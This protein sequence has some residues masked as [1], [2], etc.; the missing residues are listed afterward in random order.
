MVFTAGFRIGRFTV[1]KKLGFGGMGEVYLAEDRELNRQVALKFLPLPLC[2]DED[3]RKRFKREARAAAQL[4]HPNIVTIYEVAEFQ[5]RPFIAM[6]HIEGKSLSDII[7]KNELKLSEVL[8]LAMQICE[9]MHRAH[10]SGVIHRDI[11]PSNIMVDN[12]GRVK[13]LDFGLASI[14]NEQK[15]TRDGAVLGTS[16]YM[17]PEQIL[18]EKI[19]ERSD[20]FALGIVFYEMITGR[21]PFKKDSEDATYRAILEETPEPL[22]RFKAD[23]PEEW[24]HVVAKALEKNPSL[25]YQH[26]DECRSDLKRLQV[27]LES[28][29][30]LMRR[31]EYRREWRAYHNRI[32]LMGLIMVIA[33]ALLLTLSST[34][35]RAILRWLHFDSVPFEKHLAVLPFTCLGDV[36]AGQTF[37][38]GLMETLTT[39][40][41]QMEKFQG[42]LWVVPAREVREREV[43]SVKDARRA[44]GVTLAVTGSVQE[45]GEDIRLAL[46]LIDTRSERQ[47]HSALIDVP[48]NELVVLQDSTV[49]SIAEMLEIHLHPEQ[50][51]YLTSGRTDVPE[52]F[53]LYLAG[54]GYLQRFEK[55]ACIDTAVMKFR[56]A[57]DY[58]PGYALAYAALGEAYWRKY[59]A[60]NELEWI[61]QARGNSQVALS[62]DAQ[63]APVHITLGMIYRGTGEYEKAVREYNLARVQEPSNYEAYRGLA[64]AYEALNMFDEAVAQYRK[65]IALRPKYWAGYFDLGLFYTYH[66][67]NDKAVALLHRAARLVPYNVRDYNDIGALY[68]LLN[69]ND[70]ARRMWRQSIEIEPNYAAFSNL[71]F[72]YYKERDYEEAARMYERA[73]EI[74]DHDHNV[75]NNL[76][77]A[78]YYLPGMREKALDTYQRAIVEAEKQL[79]VNPRDPV[80]LVSLA[81]YY[82]VV[83]D[84]VKA[85]DMVDEALQLD[86][87]NTE[88]IV[89]A[90]FVFEKLNDRS[91]SVFWVKKILQLGYPPENLASYP[92]FESL[93]TDERVKKVIEEFINN[94][95]DSSS[96]SY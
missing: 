41:T 34:T 62:L 73:L 92:E 83:G 66:G 58:D 50:E 53:G 56:E 88:V 21:Q 33:L 7:R 55:S 18:G 76:A 27:K 16:G 14:K 85:R 93:L 75:W 81:Q 61:E 86:A 57:L 9:G 49:I 67:D 32:R 52:A 51:R 28:R 74:S 37:C 22:R 11:K 47:I 13:I 23:V 82:A 17:S 20:I 29:P 68:C 96:R 60:T 15:I 30:G 43:F 64:A 38:D 2:R 44:F 4:S 91:A 71:G 6:E 87:E 89:S 95:T 24:Q 48:L 90:L 46:N 59:K 19:D 65:I 72:L 36:Y 94:G 5:G 70:E 35:R 39:R 40:L 63:L 31:G 54:R 3:C 69:F 10:H 45:L 84:T 25:R 26:S 12:D 77:S 79:R 80:L 1:L 8:E 42:A 78:Y